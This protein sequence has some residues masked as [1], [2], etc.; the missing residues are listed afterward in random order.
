VHLPV[1]SAGFYRERVTDAKKGTLRMTSAQLRVTILAMIAVDLLLIFL[2]VVQYPRVL[3]LPRA[4]TFV[5]EPTLLLVA[6][7]A[8]IVIARRSL[9]AVIGSATAWGF[10]S[11][12]ISAVHIAQENYLHVSSNA[13]AMLT[14]LFIIGMFVPWAVA[15]YRSPGA[16]FLAGAWSAFVC[17]LLTVTFGWSELLWALPHVVRRN[18]GSPDLLRSGWTDLHA[19]AIVDLLQA[20]FWHLLLGVHR[21]CAWWPRTTPSASAAFRGAQR[22]SASRCSSCGAHV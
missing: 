22:L 6:A 14:W 13:T 1:A 5:L 10:L 12:V 4:W 21:R 19:F 18:I 7:A 15:G 11:G 8:V 3:A 16:G 9:D 2:P 20:G 17:M